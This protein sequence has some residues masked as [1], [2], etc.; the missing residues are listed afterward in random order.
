MSSICFCFWA[1]RRVHTF[2]IVFIVTAFYGRLFVWTKNHQTVSVAQVVIFVSLK[3]KNEW[4]KSK[5]NL[6]ETTC[7]IFHVLACIRFCW[8]ELSFYDWQYSNFERYT[9]IAWLVKVAKTFFGHLF[10]LL[11]L[12]RF[13]PVFSTPPFSL[14]S[15]PRSLGARVQIEFISHRNGRKRE[16][17]N[18][19]GK[20]VSKRVCT[21]RAIFQVFFVI[22]L[23][24]SKT[25]TVNSAVFGFQSRRL[26][27]ARN[28]RNQATERSPFI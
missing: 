26:K 22:D 4:S 8:F 19:R 2:L 6:S 14:V 13:H 28:R 3:K 15:T 21:R 17:K 1:K 27:M 11:F 16:N 12:P 10:S 25:R 5:S 23:V 7:R 9:V 20:S 24:V 18:W